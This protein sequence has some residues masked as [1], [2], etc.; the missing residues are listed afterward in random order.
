ML[1]F[2]V[3][4]NTLV[5]FKKNPEKDLLNLHSKITFHHP[6]LSCIND[7]KIL[8][9]VISQSLDELNEKELLENQ[10]ASIIVSDSLLSHSLVVNDNKDD[11][12]LA[13]KINDELQTKWKD[14]FN[15]YFYIS[16]N[17]KSSKKIIHVVEINHYLKDKIKL[18]FN[19]F[20]I[21]IKSIIPMSSI[22]LSKTKTTQYGVIKSKSDYL[23]FNY[24]RKGFAFFK[25]NYTSK[26]KMFDR[27]VGFNNLS[28]VSEATLKK[29]NSKFRLFSDI[30]VVQSLSDMIENSIPMLNFINPVGMQIVDGNLYEK[31][32]TF[33]KKTNTK[34]F[35]YH[36]RN[37]IAALLTLILLVVSLQFIN[38]RD[39]KTL[40]V[41]EG[42]F[43]D[44]K[45]VEDIIDVEGK[46]DPVSV[47]TNSSDYTQFEIYHVKS[48]AMID[49]FQSILNSEYGSSINEL[50]V[51]NGILSAKGSA[52]ITGLLIDVDPNSVKEINLSENKISYKIDLFAP[53][54]AS[55]SS[56]SISNFL[57]S[58]VDIKRTDFELFDGT[59]LD[60]KVDNL[61]IRIEQKDIFE[62]VINQIKGYNNFIVRKISFKRSDNA[63]HIYIT[64]LG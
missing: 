34:N 36:F 9:N 28:K 20:G 35:F 31:K 47:S 64:V 12:D 49:A 29:S 22:V 42:V 1:Y 37:A 6:L 30:A 46:I 13:Q 32:K 33:T 4:N 38:Q 57:N 54:Q 24:S 16:E 14:L 15:H 2:I 18:N 21:N 7:S 62:D 48:Y 40:N 27:I 5:L 52:D 39:L 43:E 60:K 3:H 61:V 23:I 44:F 53:P 26:G 56:I 45:Q 51:I 25:A 8:N 63:T 11:S 41:A 55:Q 50:S 59:L 19:N 17:K 10:D 58:V